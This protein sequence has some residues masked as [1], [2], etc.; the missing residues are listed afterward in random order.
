MTKHWL[1]KA[2]LHLMKDKHASQKTEL[3]WITHQFE[4]GSMKMHSK[5]QEQLGN[6]MNS[7]KENNQVVNQELMLKN[8]EIRK[9]KNENGTLETGLLQMVC[10]ISAKYQG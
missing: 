7:L 1:V 2:Q 5:K 8:T 4:N 3:S 9:M 6:Q 10:T